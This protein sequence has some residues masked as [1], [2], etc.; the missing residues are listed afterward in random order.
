[1]APSG[2]NST[3]WNIERDPRN[4]V[5]HLPTGYEGSSPTD[6][7]IPSCDIEDVDVAVHALFDREIGFAA[8][9]ISDGESS[10][11]QVNKPLV[12]LAGGER[13]ALVKK[14]RPIRTKKDHQ[15]ILPAIA[16][17]RKSIT[18]TPDD[19]TSRG[20]NQFT[21]D[22]VIKRRLASEDRDYQ[23]LINKLALTDLNPNGPSSTRDQGQNGP[24]VDEAV[25]EGALLD[26]K[27][28]N[29]VWEVITIPQPQFYTATYEITF[30]SS[31][32]IHMNYMVT[33]LLSAQLPQ[34]KM[35]RLNTPKGYW[36]IGEISDEVTSADN[37]EEFTEDKKVIRYT[38]QMTVKAFLL[39]SNG[40][41]MPVP[42]RRTIS[43]VEISFET[44]IPTGKVVSPQGPNLPGEP[45]ALS[46]IE[47]RVEDAQTLTSDQR[48]IV[49][50]KVAN[51]LT[52]K[53]AVKKASILGSNQKQGETAYYADGFETLDEFILAIQ[54]K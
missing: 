7:T 35:F 45:Y 16:I 44:V 21:G 8:Q 27:L 42:V 29:N 4:P 18:Q 6:Y 52:G 53:V 17:R 3:R 28:G 5:D 37:F 15:L 11:E 22:L 2:K 26:P 13:F 31:Y 10:V 12:I 46:D 34:G 1:M 51:P 9:S 47:E 41:G 48:F 40:P 19:L 50:K 14:L 25:R 38:F 43:A 36:F 24:I 49:E 23:N 39:A 32:S 20:M 54:G 33:T 30:W